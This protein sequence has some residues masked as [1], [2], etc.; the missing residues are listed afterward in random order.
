MIAMN[1][2]F[3]D[4]AMTRGKCLDHTAETELPESRH[5]ALCVQTQ[6]QILDSF[7]QLFPT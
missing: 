6:H 7:H 2:I 4:V 3:S 1:S 5:L